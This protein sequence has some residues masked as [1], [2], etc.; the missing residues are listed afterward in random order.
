M[1]QDDNAELFGPTRIRDTGGVPLSSLK[2]KFFACRSD[3]SLYPTHPSQ[4]LK[5]YHSYETARYNHLM[6]DGRDYECAISRLGNDHPRARQP[7]PATVARIIAEAEASGRRIPCQ[8]GEVQHVVYLSD[9][10]IDACGNYYR[11]V[12]YLSFLETDE[13]MGTL[14]SPGRNTMDTGRDITAG[15]V[16]GSTFPVPFSDFFSFAE[17]LPGDMATIERERAAARSTHTLDAAGRIFLR[18]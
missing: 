13:N 12:K 2:E 3:A 1:P 16:D 15:Q 4:V 14:W 17:L 5:Q 10:Y 7:N 8:M 11:G 6:L 9:T 18:N